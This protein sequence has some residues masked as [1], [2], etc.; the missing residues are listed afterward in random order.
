MSRSYFALM[1]L[2][3]E[4]WKCFFP[5]FPDMAGIGGATIYEANAA[6]QDAVNGL[7]KPYP[8]PCGM[9]EAME[10]AKERGLLDGAV[11]PDTAQMRRFTTGETQEQILPPI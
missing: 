11:F 4:Q 9:D 10:A 7:S 2:D 3:G 6:A 5:D 1:R 8:A